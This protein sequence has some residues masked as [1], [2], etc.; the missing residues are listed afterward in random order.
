MC[1]TACV[2][3]RLARCAHSA[4]EWAVFRTCT[5]TCV[6][7]LLCVRAWGRALRR[8]PLLRGMTCARGWVCAC[9]VLAVRVRVRARACACACACA[10]VCV[11]ARVPHLN[12]R[13]VAAFM[14]GVADVHFA[15]TVN[16]DD[17]YLSDDDNSRV[18]GC[19]RPR[20]AAAHIPV[21]VGG[22]RWM[23]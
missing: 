16:H 20:C 8:A 2:G 17:P 4:R 6:C 5:C 3:V 11:G 21:R 22:W 14:F 13:L 9:A 10:R 23:N 19:L 15:M 7:M 1:G 12:L 18:G